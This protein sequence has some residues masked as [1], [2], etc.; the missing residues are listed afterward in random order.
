M[1]SALTAPQEALCT[2]LRELVK[3]WQQ[4]L[5]YGTAEGILC[6]AKATATFVGRFSA[7]RGTLALASVVCF[8]LLA[9]GRASP[10][11]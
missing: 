7:G 6:K 3:S 9:G 10:S 2:G 8:S 1:S 11:R 4:N 5:P